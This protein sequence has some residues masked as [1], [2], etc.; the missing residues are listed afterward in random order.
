MQIG[1][2]S[3]THGN[4]AGWQRAW[5]LGLGESQHLVHCGDLLYHGPR[6][7]PVEGYA[8]KDLAAAINA[9]EQPVLIARGNADSEV[10]QLVLDVPIQSPYVFAV[11]DGFRLLVT[12]GHLMPPD[13]LERLAVRWKI[14]FLLTGH[15]H[16]PSICEVGNG[17]HINPGSV[18]YPLGGEGA[19]IRP[20]FCLIRDG[21]PTIFD[22]ETGE[23]LLTV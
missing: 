3:D 10:D 21:E 15:T 12:H 4:L 5:D 22:L 14:D 18:T 11:V 23:V 7:A 13:D 1:V 19:L 20:T 8:P 2:L 17:L 6:F 16:S 9:C